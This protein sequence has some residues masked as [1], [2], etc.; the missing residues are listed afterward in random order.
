MNI[1]PIR[2]PG[3]SAAL[4]AATLTVAACSTDYNA[5]SVYNLDRPSAIT[6]SCYGD[7]RITNGEAASADQEVIVSAQ[8]A[9]A[10]RLRS[11]GEV[12]AGQ[13]GDAEF[14]AA[15]VDPEFVAFALQPAKGTVALVT[16]PSYGGGVELA[17]VVD[18]DP[19]TPGKNAIPIGTLPIGLVTGHESCHLISAN[20]G[21]CDMSIIDVNSA[22][23]RNTPAAVD[24]IAVTNAS[25]EPLGA[26]PRAIVA[27]PPTHDIGYIC[28]ERPLGLVYIAYPECNLVAAV[29]PATGAVV[30]GITFDAAGAVTITDGSVSCPSQCGGEG[31]ST[32]VDRAIPRPVALE[33]AADGARLYVGAENSS[34]I[35]IVTLDGD[36]LPSATSTIVLEGDIGITALAASPAMN[37][38]GS[39][40]IFDEGSAGRFSFVYAVATDKSV[41]VAEV[42]TQMRE[43][44]TQIDA[45][46]LHDE[47]DVT[48][49]SC[50]P[51]GAPTTPPRRPGARSPGITLPRD[52]VPLD[53]AFAAVDNGGEQ[54][55]GEPS[56][57]ALVGFYAFVTASNGFAY[58]VNIDDDK[59]PDFEDP[60]DSVAAYMPL[61][62]AHQLRD[63]V[64]SRNAVDGLTSDGTDALTRCLYVSNDALEFGPRVSGAPIQS[65][66]LT[67]IASTKVHMLPFLRAVSCINENEDEVAVPELAF[68]ADLETRE[69]AFPDITG[70]ENE[71]W[72]MTWEGSVSLDTADV[73]LDG[74]PVRLGFVEY[75]QNGADFALVDGGAPF[76]RAGLEPYDFVV[77]GG[78]DPGVGD[79][80]CSV[81]E[82]CYVHPETPTSV[83]DGLCLPEDKVEQLSGQCKDI[84]T[85]RRRYT[86]LETY[87]DHLVLGE[88]RRVLRTTPIAGCESD[89]QCDDFAE[90]AREITLDEHPLAIALDPPEQSY[91][92][93]CE[94]DPSRAPGPDR[95]VMTCETRADCEDGW[96]CSGGYCVEG[97]IPPPQCF[98]ALQRY[99]LRVGDALAVVGQRSGFLHNRIADPGTGA[100]IDDPAANPLLLGRLPL[101]APPCTGD[102]FTDFDVNPCSTTIDHIEEYI[103]YSG[104]SCAAQDVALRSREVTAIRFEN[105]AMRFHL[106]DPTTTGD[107]TCIGDREGTWPAFSAMHPGFQLRFSITGAYLPMFV[108]GLTVAFPINITPGPEGGLW[109]LDQGDVYSSLS[110]RGR[111]VHIDPAAANNAFSPIT[112]R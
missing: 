34:A 50:V 61:A 37:M 91:A 46:Y 30:A 45:R 69:S 90:L 89:I 23:D 36:Y 6:F 19:L 29:E 39:L 21:S 101:Q 44:D 8:P 12:P 32:P 51:V 105:P 104:D 103:P 40:G 33:M 56:P 88:R 72:L 13:E 76:C 110:T 93:S 96:A 3:V 77:F 97:Q 22:L 65:L 94:A 60:N 64:S 26:K 73:D 49:L 79:N 28:P 81:G 59:Y 58:V 92:W 17:A 1:L 4:V 38:G 68:A 55:E 71:Q 18:T 84:L 107:A 11:V 52:S 24:R 112:L 109:I 111:I 16:Y 63:F 66:S 20:A 95:C 78:C 83:D 43:C 82:V 25:G 99:Q 47:S 5:V 85:S 15:P 35:T 53:V 86:I 41:R 106:V 27:Q 42:S 87:T 102:G 100:C 9:E 57:I 75:D 31:E 2:W 10:C 80:H 48:W 54:L 74:P 14:G 108:A 98:A 7:V 62:M 70:T 67:S